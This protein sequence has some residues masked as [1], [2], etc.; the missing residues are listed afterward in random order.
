[1]LCITGCAVADG[2]GGRG[3]V[4]HGRG[5]G[6]HVVILGVRGQMVGVL[7]GAAMV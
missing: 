7:W 4:A 6:G 2:R 3:Q 5:G 1:M